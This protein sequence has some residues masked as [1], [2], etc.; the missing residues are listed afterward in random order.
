MAKN[1]VIVESP[2]KARTLNKFLGKDYEVAASGGHIRDL[3]PKS[4]GVNIEKDF[5]PTYKVIKGK[6]KI[7][8]ELKAKAKKA[9]MIFLAP[10][11]DREGEAIA[12]HLKHLIGADSK[13]KRIEFHEITKTAVENA[14]AHP[15]EIDE[16]RVNAQQARR[17][18]DRLVGFKLSP[19]LWRKVRKGLSAGRVQSVAVRLICEREEEIKKFIPEEYWDIIAHLETSEKEAF[20]AK[21][22]AKGTAAM[23]NRPQEKG[24]VI[25]SDAEAKNIL[26]ELETAQYV[27]K[28]IRKKEQ[29]RH[30]AA[31]FI[32]STLQQEA[33]RKLGF[34]PKKT[35]MMAQRLYE[36]QEVAGEGRVGLITYMRTDSVRIAAEAESAV[37]EYITA[38]FGKEFL[39]AKPNVYKSRKTAQEAHEAIR[40][41]SLARTP[42]KIKEGLEPDEFKLYDLIWKRFVACQ[43]EKAIFDQTS[44]DIAAGEYIFRATG[45]VIK[46]DGFLK[47][48]E[49]SQDH[50]EEEKE[51]TLPK[52]EDNEKLNLLEILPAQHF[53]QPPPRY[54][55]ASLVKE[56][57]N[58][59]IGRPST[60]APILS[61]VQDRGYVEKEGKALKPT[62]IGVVTN[63]LLVKSFPE[64]MD[65]KFTAR[66]EDQLDDVADAKLDWVEALKEFY[67]PF[68]KALD[69]AEE[70][71]EKVKKEVLVEEKCPDCGNQ[72]MMRS[73][74]YG[75]FL[76]CS[77]YPKCKY[78]KNLK[79]ETAQIPE[80][81]AK[82]EKCG[83]PMVLKHGRFGSF[84]ACSGYPECKTTKPFAKPLGVKCPKC[85]ADIVQRKTKKG[86]MFYGCIT[87]PKCDFATWQRPVAPEEPKKETPEGSV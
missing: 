21:L 36:G 85:G 67:D 56:L 22:V 30:P 60:Y 82:C 68:K 59:G 62:E 20:K 66:M 69:I 41:T 4:L 44:V 11:P 10:D 84:L 32:T 38:T 83:K 70:K 14:V 81:E 78:T 71:M 47:V 50:E 86:K 51:G 48:Y 79:E 40:P 3:P 39:P 58:K 80:G 45:S 72:L 27:I 34:S 13:I 19:L 23:G 8:E 65:V 17:I 6:E 52:L 9:K 77:T 35:M 18:L 16:D 87:Y 55:E 25:P 31:P 54:T 33:A 15:R 37:R 61:T 63:G 73:G 76:A 42:E 57:E 64:V 53:T 7:V 5:A 29:N 46:F 1:L 74:R 28:E 49:E 12:W 43:M 75:D 2:S 24:K 26:K